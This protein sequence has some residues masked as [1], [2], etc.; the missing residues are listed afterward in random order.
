MLSPI[1]YFFEPDA[2][3][4][5]AALQQQQPLESGGSKGFLPVVGAMTATW[6]EARLDIDGEALAARVYRPAVPLRPAPLVLHLHGGCFVDG[7]LDCSAHLCRIMAEAGAV[8]VSIDYPLAPEHPFPAALNL[9]F[10]AL[11]RLY[12]ERAK[13]AGRGA[14]LFVAGEEAGANLATALTLMARDQQAPPLAGQILIS[15]MVDPSLC[16]GSIHAASAGASGCKWADGWHLYLGS[17]DRAAHPYA[18]PL[19]SRRLG[20]L[21]PVL[22]VTSADCPIRDESLAYAERLRAGG[23]SVESH[24]LEGT[25]CSNQSIDAAIEAAP[26][27]ETVLRGLFSTFLAEHS[28]APLR[29]IRA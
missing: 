2:G 17:A 24:L 22:I 23:V 7:D 18:A 27:W 21:A 11:G 3:L 5:F 1:G 8:V 15:P 20:G 13:W 4:V 14:R 25:N 6:T 12:A 26:A 16:T 28:A 19:G 29:T 10:K 9:S